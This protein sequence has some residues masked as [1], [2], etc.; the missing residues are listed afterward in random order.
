MTMNAMTAGLFEDRAARG[1]ARVAKGNW[2]QRVMSRLD[3]RACQKPMTLRIVDKGKVLGWAEERRLYQ[4]SARFSRYFNE[5]AS[6]DWAVSRAGRDCLVTC[7]VH[8]RSGFYRVE[9]VAESF[10][11]AI[12]EALDRVVRQRRRRKAIAETARRNPE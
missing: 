3:P 2:V 11:R 10:G 8:A 12:D 9:G 1:Q 4:M 5:I 7:K 6:I